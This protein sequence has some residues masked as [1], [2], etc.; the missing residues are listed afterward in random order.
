MD[1]IVIASAAR[2]PVGSFLGTYGIFV[3]IA[4][5]A[6][7]V[8]SVVFN[9]IFPPVMHAILHLAIPGGL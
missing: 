2:T 9:W 8:L 6:T 3:L 1:D 5:M 7:G 4:L